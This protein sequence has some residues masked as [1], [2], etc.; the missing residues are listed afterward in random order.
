METICF[1]E[2]LA[3][4]DESTRRPNQEEHNNPHR[5]ENL[6]SHHRTSVHYIN[7]ADDTASKNNCI[8]KKVKQLDLLFKEVSN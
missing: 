2:T 1:S 8:T 6:K 7:L 5:R 4:T 3:S